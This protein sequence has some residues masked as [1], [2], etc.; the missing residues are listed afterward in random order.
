MVKARPGA[1]Y[2][3]FLFP[4]QVVKKHFVID[5]VLLIGL[6]QGFEDSR[7]RVLGLQVFLQWVKHSFG[8][9]N[10]IHDRFYYST[11]DVIQVSS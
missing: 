9:N 6:G 10:L 1:T 7:V 3:L 8:F 11:V 4:V 5:S 2:K